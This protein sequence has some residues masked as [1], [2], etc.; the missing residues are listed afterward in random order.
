MYLCWEEQKFDSFGFMMSVSR[1]KHSDTCRI[2]LMIEENIVGVL[3]AL[4]LLFGM[5]GVHE[6]KQRAYQ[7]LLVVVY[8]IVC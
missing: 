4:S 1:I 2:N 6:S 5:L 8:F 3:G 7:L